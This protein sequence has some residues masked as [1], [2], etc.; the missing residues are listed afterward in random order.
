MYD[1]LRLTIASIKGL[2]AFR[3]AS[4]EVIVDYDKE[5]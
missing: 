3:P 5:E 4:D 2:I 1:N